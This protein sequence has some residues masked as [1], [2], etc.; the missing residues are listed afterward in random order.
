[1]DLNDGGAGAPAA[2]KRAGAG[3]GGGPARRRA[4]GAGGCRRRWRCRRGRAGG[5]GG[6]RPA[7]R[8]AW[9]I[10]ISTQHLSA[11]AEG[12]EASLR[13]WAKSAGSRISTGS[14]R[15]LRDN[16]KALRDSGR[17]K[18]PGE[19]AT[20][21][22]SPLPQ[23]DRRARQGRGLQA[24]G[25]QGR[26]R[27][28]RADEQRQARGDRRDRAQARHPGRARGD[29]AGDRPGRR[30]RV[31]DRRRRDPAPGRGARQEVGRREAEKTAAVGRA[32]RG[33]RLDARPR[34]WRS[35]RR[36]RPERALDIFAK[37]GAGCAR[38]RWSRAASASGSACRAPRRRRSST[39]RRRTPSGRQGDGAGLGRAD[40]EYNR[41]V[42]GDRR[43]GKPQSG[44]A[45]FFNSTE[46][47]DAGAG[48]IL[49]LRRTRGVA[50]KLR[51]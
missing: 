49:G 43:G 19:G 51:T 5:G 32:A 12:D 18:V 48:L 42:G 6:G 20:P 37:L 24:A 41:L 47:I 44:A 36:S 7:A 46:W 50:S 38:T 40:A 30:A 22:R 23:G 26:G 28:R 17:V 29:A 2:V 34:R 14:P 33:A 45:R 15:S 39:R 8:P 31:L 21:K 9:P 1:M 10:P 35:A 16:Q 4:A 11:D 3:F 13:D 27:Q 25:A